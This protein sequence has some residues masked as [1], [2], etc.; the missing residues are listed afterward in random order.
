MRLGLRTSSVSRVI[1]SCFLMQIKQGPTI[2][3]QPG[4]QARIVHMESL[5][6]EFNLKF[7]HLLVLGIKREAKLPSAAPDS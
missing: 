7:T 1:L 5:F 4:L 3:V 2:L 6:P